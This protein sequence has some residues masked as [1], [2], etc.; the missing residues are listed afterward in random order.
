MELKIFTSDYSKLE[1][2]LK[3]NGLEYKSKGV[4]SDPEEPDAGEFDLYHVFS[5]SYESPEELVDFICKD[6]NWSIDLGWIDSAGD[7][8]N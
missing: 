7:M 1:S 3:R 8:C 5:D 6:T 2:W 4:I